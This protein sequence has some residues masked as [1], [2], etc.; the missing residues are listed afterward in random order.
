MKNITQLISG[1]FLLLITGCTSTNDT[2]TT[3]DYDTIAVNYENS[4]GFSF[5]PSNDYSVTFTFPSRIYSSD[6]VLVYRL[7]G[8]SNGNDLWKS[9]PETYYFD[10][11]TRDYT[12]TYDFSVNDV[13]IYLDGNDLGSLLNSKKLNQFFRFVVV[14]A[15][16]VYAMKDTSNYDQVIQTLKKHQSKTK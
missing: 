7:V 5:T 8:A 2:T 3:V 9:L 16:L 13:V 15:D 10:D 1:L 4:I 14:P 11:G 12:Y 6:M